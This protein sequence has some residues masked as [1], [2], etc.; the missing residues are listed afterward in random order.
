M[1][2]LRFI[3]FTWMS[4]LLQK[5]ILNKFWND[6][7]CKSLIRVDCL[8]TYGLYSPWNSPGQNTAEGICSLDS[9]LLEMLDGM[10]YW[11]TWVWASSWSWWSTGKPVFYNPWGRRVRHNWATELNWTELF[12]S[13][14]DLPNPGIK[15]RSPTFQVDFFTIWIN[16]KAP[17]SIESH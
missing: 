15:P 16:R 11:W 7:K 2:N 4:I 12:H 3:N 9:S 8:Q 1:V 10:T 5:G 13:P 6:M 14:G 17:K